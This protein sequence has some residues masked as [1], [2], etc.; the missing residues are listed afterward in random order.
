MSAHSTAAITQIGQGSRHGHRNHVGESERIIRAVP[1]T[2]STTRA[3]PNDDVHIV[4]VRR[5]G[6][7]GEFCGCDAHAVLRGEGTL[8]GVWI[9][10]PSHRIGATSTS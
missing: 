2:T 10:R 9:H 8:L 1:T 5:D 6:A 7:L 4:N 3:A